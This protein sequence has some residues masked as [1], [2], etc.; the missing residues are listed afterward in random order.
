M[1]RLL[2]CVLTVSLIA[3]TCSLDSSCPGNFSQDS[4][5]W[6]WHAD[7]NPASCLR[8]GT[9]LYYIGNSITRGEF[10]S[11]A[12][13]LQA[14]G[15]SVDLCKFSGAS[16]KL[17]QR[18]TNLCPKNR[19]RSR[20]WKPKRDDGKSLEQ[21]FSC[22]FVQSGIT[23]AYRWADTLEEYISALRV[24]QIFKPHAIFM[25]IALQA[26][27]IMIDAVKRKHFFKRFASVLRASELTGN[28]LYVKSI[29]PVI[30]ATLDTASV[31]Q[32]V[33][34]SQRKMGH[35]HGR[36]WNNVQ[37]LS[38][39]RLVRE[40]SI[41]LHATYIDEWTILYPN[42]S[43]L[44]ADNVHPNHIATKAKL[45][46]SLWAFCSSTTAEG[47]SRVVEVER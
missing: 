22:Y 19:F 5:K 29:N 47:T 15:G 41:T 20:A 23:I 7:V 27:E 4:K 11:L 34:T 42:M 24:T 6:V 26:T 8:T 21:S 39:N 1:K 46:C 30:E 35:G 45:D 9:L 10:F 28:V 14:Q 13:E 33:T 2:S 17:R 32:A 18:Q 12:C 36:T 3:V 40:W 37:L 38:I 44:Y 43:Q 31:E 25:Q 16:G